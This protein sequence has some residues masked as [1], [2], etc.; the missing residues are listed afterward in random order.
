MHMWQQVI[1]NGRE[2]TISPSTNDY[3]PAFK[4]KALEDHHLEG[5]HALDF[6]TQKSLQP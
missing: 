5:A 1:L 3:K 4:E 2:E 6:E